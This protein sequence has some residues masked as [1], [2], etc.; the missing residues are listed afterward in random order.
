MTNAGAKLHRL[1]NGVMNV[2]T[3]EIAKL[4]LVAGNIRRL[5][6]D[7]GWTTVVLAERSNVN[8]ST[9]SRLLHAKHDPGFLKLDQI[10]TALKTS[11]DFLLR[12]HPDK[13]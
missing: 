10:A 2:T 7:R 5:M 9:I 3:E 12:S 4:E 6:V 13:I 1:Y 8:R 11:V